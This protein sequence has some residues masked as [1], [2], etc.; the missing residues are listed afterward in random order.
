MVL[1]RA[2]RNDAQRVTGPDYRWMRA[3]AVS[4]HATVLMNR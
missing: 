2:L 3:H 4:A 1:A